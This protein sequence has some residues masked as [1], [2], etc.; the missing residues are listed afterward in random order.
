[1]RA[2]RFNIARPE[3]V[4]RARSRT[5]KGFSFTE[6]LFAVMIL[7]IGF[8]M[9]AAIFPVAIHQAKT[10]TEETTAA[11][12]AR[13]AAN[14][15]EKIAT[16]STMPAT[17]NRLVAAD[18]DGGVLPLPAG[19]PRDS[20]GYSIGTA[21][22]GSLVV[23]SN[24]RYAWIPFY[25]RA[26]LPWDRTTW[27]PFAHVIM[28]PVQVRNRT[29]FPIAPRVGDGTGVLGV[30]KIRGALRNG[31][32]G[33]ADTVT[34]TNEVNLQ[35]EGAYLI[36]ADASQPG[37]L[38]TNWNLRVAPELNGRIYR[39]GNRDPNNPIAGWELMPGFDFTPITVDADGSALTP[40]AGNGKEEVVGDDAGDLSD[41]A[42]FVVGRGRD[43]GGN[44]D[45]PAQD[46]SAYSTIV[47]IK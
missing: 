5:S 19:A 47:G 2:N 25:R 20:D 24:T 6:V 32:N 3:P 17:N 33:A 36:I 31:V 26:G 30:A 8:I 45:G 42:F 11:S 29:E 9:V 18:Y 4:E 10:S 35:S 46:V 28:V 37:S 14:Y 7:G 38:A 21:L 40:A 34:F 22:N 16:D 39:L 12:V 43:A 44:Y 13:G 41:I 23:D 27:S 1:M 15:L